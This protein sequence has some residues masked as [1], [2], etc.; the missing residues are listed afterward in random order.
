MTTEQDRQETLE[1]I[2]FYMN[3]EIIPDTQSF[4]LRH[5]GGRWTLMSGAQRRNL[6]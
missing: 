4:K 6:S 5:Q 2:I 1:L 3:H